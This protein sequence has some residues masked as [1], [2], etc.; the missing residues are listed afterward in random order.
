M[1]ETQHHKYISLYSWLCGS[2]CSHYRRKSVVDRTME[3]SGRPP[4]SVNCI[5]FAKFDFN[6][7]VDSL[8]L[9][10]AIAKSTSVV[11]TGSCR[12]GYKPYYRHPLPVSKYRHDHDVVIKKIMS[13][14]LEKQAAAAVVSR[15]AFTLEEVF[16]KGAPVHL[17]DN[18]NGYTPLHLA[19][20]SNNIECVMLLLHIGVDVNALS[21]SGATSLYLAGAPELLEI[22]TLLLAAGAKSEKERKQVVHTSTVLT[23]TPPNAKA[24]ALILSAQGS[25]RP[26]NMAIN[27]ASF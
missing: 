5:K 2:C 25:R 4:R 23:Y 12:A 20:Q 3:S 24:A 11:A 27:H 6:S 1:R 8:S 14:P 17:K 21:A 16:M 9:L 22:R 7:E 26:T 15:D 19:V 13:C 10:R 18:M